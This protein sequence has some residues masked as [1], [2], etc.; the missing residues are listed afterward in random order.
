MVAS[1]EIVGFSVITRSDVS[2]LPV[3]AQMMIGIEGR[4]TE[5]I[6]ARLLGMT[7]V[8]AVHATN[9]KWDLIAEI[10]TRTLEELDGV[11]GSIRRLEGVTISE[12]NLLL[13][14]RRSTR[15]A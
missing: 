13:S 7:A 12:T 4:G 6:T 15:N 8:L 2:P 5:R 14:S 3:R 9:G 10:G 11:I 1:G